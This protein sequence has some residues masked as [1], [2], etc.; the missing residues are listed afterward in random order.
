MSPR[1][2]LNELICV[3]V[4]TA[5]AGAAIPAEID[6][7]KPAPTMT[8]KNLDFLTL[9]PPLVRTDWFAHYRT[10]PPGFGLNSGNRRTFA[11]KL[12][13]GYAR[14]RKASKGHRKARRKAARGGRKDRNGFNWPP[15]GHPENARARVRHA[16]RDRRAPRARS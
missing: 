10:D 7:A 15:S 11:A 13:Q 2:S 1:K 3:T 8:A 16:G 5:N 14:N 12:E 6:T 4:F 9:R